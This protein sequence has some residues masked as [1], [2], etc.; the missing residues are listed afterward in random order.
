[1][2]M[3]DQV[4]SLC[5][6][7]HFLLRNIGSIRKSITY[8][9]CDRMTHVLI[10]SQL[11]YCNAT[12]Y[13]IPEAQSQFLQKMFNITART[14]TSTPPSTDTTTVLLGKLHWLPV[15]KRIQCMILLL[16]FKALHGLLSEVLELQVTERT[17]RLGC[18]FMR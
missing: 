2:S 11:D 10:T 12:L 5:M 18:I 4:T 8:E 17:T 15:P 16:T 7:V 14:L 6:A 1:M 9:A 13:G 3:K